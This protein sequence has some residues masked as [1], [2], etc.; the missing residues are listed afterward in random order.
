MAG[1]EWTNTSK[2]NGLPG[3]HAGAGAVSTWGLGLRMAHLGKTRVP[4]FPGCIA[5][6]SQE[7]SEVTGTE[8]LPRVAV[9]GPGCAHSG[10]Q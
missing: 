5:S 2:L 1:A 3:E 6:D 9:S 4:T 10:R 7:G 8:P